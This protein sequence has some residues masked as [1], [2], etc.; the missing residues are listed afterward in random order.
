MVQS[1]S[2]LNKY[3]KIIINWLMVCVLLVLTTLIIG[4][5]TRLENAGLS[6][7]EWRPITGIIPPLS[8]LD[9][10]N[11][12]AKYQ[13]SPEYKLIN[14]HIT[15]SDFKYIFSLEYIHRVAG[16]LVG[17][18]FTLPY[19][20]LLTKDYVSGRIK[21]RLGI[22][23]SLIAF[24]GMLG[25]FMVQSGLSKDPHVSHFRLAAHLVTALVIYS[26][27]VMIILET[28]FKTYISRRNNIDQPSS[29]ALIM[30]VL[31]FCQI[32][33]GAFV[34]GLDAGMIYNE[35][36]NMG[37][38]YIP[39]ETKKIGFSED[40]FFDQASVQFIHRN[41]AY[42]LTIY[43]VW[44]AVFTKNINFSQF[45]SGIKYLLLTLA[46]QFIIGI[47]VVLFIVPT[48]LA[49]IHQLF[50]VFLL[51]CSLYIYF[52]LRAYSVN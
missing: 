3:D 22:I 37:S 18:I 44:F 50:A 12:F 8:Q 9:W 17:I 32:T 34:A 35:F 5:L 39:E 20:F 52:T 10:Q 31:I 11:E 16:R 4:G 21:V 49:L 48:Y 15:L 14:K 40:L 43:I 33:L 13:T 19:L 27:M 28:Y 29:F 1:S 38:N 24:Q 46:I 6:I 26:L 7:V 41:F 2:V 47:A 45:R 42:F 36:P 25:W 51:T 23:L 30:I